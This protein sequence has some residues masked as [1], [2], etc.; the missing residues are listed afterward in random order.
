MSTTATTAQI[1]SGG[2][3]TRRFHLP[4][5]R[6]LAKFAIAA[7]LFGVIAAAAL[8]V[9]GVFVAIGAVVTLAAL[10]VSG[11]LLLVLKLLRIVPE[12]SPVFY[13]RRAWHASIEVPA[14][15]TRKAA[16]VML[17]TPV[18]G[19]VIREV[20]EEFSDAGVVAKFERFFKQDR[21]AHDPY[22]YGD[23]SRV[24]EAEYPRARHVELWT[25]VPEHV[26][27]SLIQHSRL[28]NGKRLAE[29][30][31]PNCI[32]SKLVAQAARRS[33]HVFVLWFAVA[34]LLWHP[35]VLIGT[36]VQPAPVERVHVV[37]RDFWSVEDR[38]AFEEAQAARYDRVEKLRNVTSTVSAA[39][40]TLPIDALVAAL[41]ALYIALGAFRGTIAKAVSS[42]IQPFNRDTPDATTLWNQSVRDRKDA[43]ENHV[44]QIK[45]LEYDKTPVVPL[46]KA[47]GRMEALGVINAPRGPSGLS[48]TGG[49]TMSMSFE[50]LCS[51]L[52][53]LAGIGSGKSRKLLTPLFEELIKI[54]VIDPKLVS[55]WITDAK[56]VLWKDFWKIVQKYGLEKDTRIIGAKPGQFAVDLF[57]GRDPQLVADLLKGVM[58]QMSGGGSSDEFWVGMACHHLLQCLTVLRA[59]EFT[60]DADKFVDEF[61]CCPYSPAGLEKMS[62]E[63]APYAISDRIC[64]AVMLAVE[65]GNHYPAFGQYATR[66]LVDSIRSVQVEWRAHPDVTRGGFLANIVRLLSGFRS[67]PP[68]RAAFGT[69]LATNTISVSETRDYICM[70]DLSSGEYGSAGNLVNVMLKGLIY[71]EDA[72]RQVRGETASGG[73]RF[74]MMD[75]MQTLITAANA[76]SSGTYDDGN[77]PNLCRSS[78]FAYVCAT[79]STAALK[80][81]LSAEAATNFLDGMRSRIVGSV[82][83][84]ETV[85]W[86]AECIG[87]VKRMRVPGE[88][89]LFESYH[90]FREQTGFDIFKMVADKPRLIENPTDIARTCWLAIEHA[91][92]A[93]LPT[94]FDDFRPLYEVDMR[95]VTYPTSALGLGGQGGG[96]QISTAQ[97]IQSLGA[98]HHRMEDKTKDLLKDWY[99]DDLIKFSDMARLFG[100]NKAIAYLQCADSQRFDVMT[101]GD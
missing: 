2:E 60:H 80:S 44:K 33:L 27:V 55:F 87:K 4:P 100:N 3:R 49:D 89:G 65:T 79:Q 9:S 61:G 14:W 57:H 19:N 25:E 83:S 66:E 91:Q 51:N 63:V 82:E 52:L 17:R 6:K 13:L 5:P 8:V 85:E 86:I 95:F 40:I 74:A 22:L 88:P 70:C 26:R 47:T 101:I 99:E 23:L 58:N 1:D 97:Y 31:A 64:A 36:S 71:N 32:D 42:R 38:R 11:L 94:E 76:I 96:E 35:A 24:A 72:A 62:T 34:L 53:I 45:K 93:I 15:I 43:H 73:W 48:G 56:G 75:E 81:V 30:M 39:A 67:S 78:R 84:R 98:A 18:L 20:N 7:L 28:P 68:M 50:D 77:W 54:R 21:F 69:A 59:Y 92:E 46:G 41:F 16:G 12:N 29:G 37:D 90:F 10:S